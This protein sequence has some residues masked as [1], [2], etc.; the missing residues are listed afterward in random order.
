MDLLCLPQIPS[1]PAERTLYVC[2]ERYDGG[3]FLTYAHRK[4]KTRSL[5]PQLRDE[6]VADPY[7]E[8]LHPS[9]QEEQQR[10]YQ[11]WLF[12]GLLAEFLSLNKQ[13]D[14]TNLIESS[15]AKKELSE[16]YVD[17]LFLENGNNYI[18]AS[19]ILKCQ[20]LIVS[21]IREARVPAR[22]RLSYLT[23]CLRFAHIMLNSIHT[24]F[25][26]SI[27]Y[28]IAGLGELFSFTL[29]PLFQLWKLDRPHIA[30]PWGRGYLEK[31]KV[32]ML[33]AGWCPSDIERASF[34]YLGLNTQHLLSHMKK[35]VS[36]RSHL[37]CTKR[38]C[39][40]FQIDL[41]NY[42]LAHAKLGCECTE[43]GI[44]MRKVFHILQ[45]TS[46]FP[47]LR[48]NVPEAGEEGLQISVE[49]HKRGVPY[50]ALS[51]VSAFTTS[52]LICY[53]RR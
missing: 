29:Y 22:D 13:N 35:F 52:S 40:A 28:S 8:V 53:T 39:Q 41:Q 6:S 31:N 18:Q 10:F 5:P 3:P 51:H 26:D 2:R 34:T 1:L 45:K 11:T 38:Q 21:R 9:P 47:L 4:G 7:L 23:E 25:D 30:F 24:E 50:V 27:R 12:F 32:K 43:I 36:G 16:L 33:Q 48:I 19:K 37:K 17:Y 49:E 44:D 20:P 15:I 42:K 14:G 46:S